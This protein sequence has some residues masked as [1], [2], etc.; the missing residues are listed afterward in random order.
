MDRELIRHID[1]LRVDHDLTRTDAIEIL[2][3]AVW[4]TWMLKEY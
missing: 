2:L 1:H 4:W 3:G